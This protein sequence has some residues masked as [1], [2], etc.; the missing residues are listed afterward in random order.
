VECV[1]VVKNGK[2]EMRKVI[3]GIQDNSYIEIKS[4]LN[5]NEE[6]VNGP[7]SAIAKKLKNGDPVKVVPKDQLFNIKEED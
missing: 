2:V 5:E 3:T 1:F 7:Y 4:G 6:V